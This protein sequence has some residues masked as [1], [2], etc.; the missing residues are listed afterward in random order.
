MTTSPNI[1]Y[2]EAALAAMARSERPADA[3]LEACPRCR[4]LYEFY[5]TYLSLESEEFLR[6]V[7]DRDV[8]RANGIISPGIYRLE[9]FQI[10]LN[11]RTSESSY[12]PVLL[13]ALDN[14][15]SGIRFAT[16]ATFASQAIQT[17]VRVVRDTRSN[18]HAVHVLA[19][20]HSLSRDIEVGISDAT[21]QLI[22]VR[23]N[24][25]G[26]ALLR[27]PVSIDWA[28]ARLLLFVPPTPQL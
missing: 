20:D 11:V 14:S 23:T 17:V 25:E 19:S 21:G 16:I 5:R 24:G 7:S 8:E 12:S 1:H 13:A 4:G 22:K 15:D 27:T 28:T 9:S 10:P 6:P 3:H 18:E 2:D 26:V